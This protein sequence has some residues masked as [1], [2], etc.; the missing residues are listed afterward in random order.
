[1]DSF[2]NVFVD[3]LKGLDGLAGQVNW[4]SHT[5]FA[6]DENQLMVCRCGLNSAQWPNV[7]CSEQMFINQIREISRAAY[8]SWKNDTGMFPDGIEKTESGA[9]LA[10]PLLMQCFNC[11][12]DQALAITI[13]VIF[14]KI[15]SAADN[16]D[17]FA[18]ALLQIY[19][20]QLKEQE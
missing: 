8:E 19:R 4:R 18:N 11:T 17:D 13:A 10:V 20:A 2:E 3:K 15:H 6:L 16:V 7:N 14:A 1:M 12:K 5:H 9:L